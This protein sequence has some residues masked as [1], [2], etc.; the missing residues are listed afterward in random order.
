MSTLVVFTML[1]NKNFKTLLCTGSNSAVL[2][3]LLIQ[4]GALSQKIKLDASSFFS[5]LSNPS[6]YPVDFSLL[7][8]FGIY[9]LAAISDVTTIDSYQKILVIKGLA[10]HC[11]L[12]PSVLPFLAILH[13]LVHMI[14]IKYIQE[15]ILLFK[16]F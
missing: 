6:P 8:I 16:A 14:I 1:L 5:L 15:I 2:P 4:R 12:L 9:L 7:Y 11:R 13:L 3:V 10:S